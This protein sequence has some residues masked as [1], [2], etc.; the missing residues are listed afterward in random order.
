MMHEIEII[1]KID[2][3]I[4]RKS[5]E[6]G[7]EV[8]KPEH[9]GNVVSILRENWHLFLEMHSPIVSSLS[10]QMSIY[11]EDEAI[12]MLLFPSPV[13]IE[14]RNTDQFIQL[15]NTANHYLYRG[16]ALGR[17]WVDVDN[18]D[19]T[20]EIILKK[21]LAEYHA[22]ELENQLF[23]IPYAHFQDLHIPLVM[24]AAN[25]WKADMAINYLTEL[26]EKGYVDNSVYGLW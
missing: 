17:F 26:R 25:A 18:L 22:A 7:F 15:S 2:E 8:M 12:R 4:S 21:E 11:I 24:L 16:S 19:F 23:D 13:I 9:S 1:R 3:I 5:N 14:S 10:L 20:Y 6:I